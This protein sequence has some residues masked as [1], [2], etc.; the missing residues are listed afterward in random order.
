MLD[1]PIWENISQVRSVALTRDGAFFGT[2]WLRE[3]ARDYISQL[4]RQGIVQLFAS[5]D[6]LELAAVCDRVVVFFNGRLCAVLTAP[7]LSAQTIL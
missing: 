1:K 5:K 3:R 6:P 7:N 2:A 4:A